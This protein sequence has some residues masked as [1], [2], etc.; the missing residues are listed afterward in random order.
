MYAMQINY[1]QKMLQNQNW[2]CS[3]CTQEKYPL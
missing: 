2:E 1:S 3:K